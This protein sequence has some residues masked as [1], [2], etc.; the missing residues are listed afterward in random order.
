MPQRI[1]PER[2]TEE[3]LRIQ[4]RAEEAFPEES[5]EVALRQYIVKNNVQDF[6]YVGDDRMRTIRGKGNSSSLLKSMTFR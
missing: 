4:E 5:P 3:L 6:F 2:N 1:S